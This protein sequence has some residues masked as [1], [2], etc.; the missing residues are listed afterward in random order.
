MSRVL[1]A[2]AGL[3]GSLCACLLRREMQSKVHIEVWDK[4]RAAGES[5]PVPEPASGSG[6]SL[7]Q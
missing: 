5:E 7:E 4:A 2:G 6:C 1:I 3:T